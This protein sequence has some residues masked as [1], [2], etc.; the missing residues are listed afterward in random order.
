MYVRKRRLDY[1][2]EI[3]KFQGEHGEID[4]LGE[5][6]R[7]TESF[8]GVEC[9]EVGLFNVEDKLELVDAV[10]RPGL[11]LIRYKAVLLS[12]RIEPFSI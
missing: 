6:V 10:W 11:S 4:E 8:K 1:L 9:R 2:R 12:N 7:N 3:S 5:L